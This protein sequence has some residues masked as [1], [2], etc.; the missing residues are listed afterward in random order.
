MW[1]HERLELVH[2]EDRLVD[3]MHRLRSIIRAIPE[4]LRTSNFSSCNSLEQ[5][6]LE[7]SNAP[8]SATEGRQ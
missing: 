5:L 4:T 3:Y 2:G 1:I 6:R 8:R 7:L